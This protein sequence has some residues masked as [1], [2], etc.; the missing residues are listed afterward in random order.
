FYYIFCDVMFAFVV[1]RAVHRP[2]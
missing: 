1:F 2:K